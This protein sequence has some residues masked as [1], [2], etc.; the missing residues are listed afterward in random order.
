MSSSENSKFNTIGYRK[1]LEIFLSEI[2]KI[3]TEGAEKFF[4]STYSN[5]E[6]SE[7]SNIVFAIQKKQI[8]WIFMQLN[9]IFDKEIILG[10]KKDKNDEHCLKEFTR[11]CEEANLGIHHDNCEES[12]LC[13][14]VIK[15]FN[16]YCDNSEF[17]NLYSKIVEY[18]ENS[19]NFK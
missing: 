2:P 12:A 1:D 18:R 11:L 15:E 7:I 6:K 14:R 13:N 8:L 10:I 3:L 4:R 16:D 9:N 19:E 5:I 17:L